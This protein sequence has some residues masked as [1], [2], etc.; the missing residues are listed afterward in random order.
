MTFSLE[1]CSQ[2]CKLGMYTTPQ[3][4]FIN[5]FAFRGPVHIRHDTQVICSSI[6]CFSF[7]SDHTLFR[8]SKIG[9]YS[10]IAEYVSMG[11]GQHDI[12]DFSTSN[13]FCNSHN[14]DFAG[15]HTER[16]SPLQAARN[17]VDTAHVIIGNDVWVGAHVVF[18]KDVTVGHG[19]VIGSG[20]VITKRE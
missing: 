2:L 6:D 12:Y 20:A 14:F 13:V 7:I 11:L 19:A 3:T 5:R 9:R 18:P 15:Y 16:L 10:S 1:I 17:N 8:T 4:F